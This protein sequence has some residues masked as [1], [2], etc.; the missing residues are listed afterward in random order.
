MASSLPDSPSLDR[1]KA[2]ARRLQRA[3][4]TGDVEA[5]ALY[6]RWHPKPEAAQAQHFPLHSAQLTIARRYGFTGWPALV[7]YLELA[8]DFSRDPGA[9]D[10]TSLSP[11][12]Q[13]CALA[14]LRYD[15]SDE[16]P[17]WAAA[18]AMLADQPD[19]VDAHIWAAAAAGDVEAIRRHL[20]ADPRLTGAQ[21]GPYRW[22]PLLYLVYSRVP[23]AHET[24]APAAASV[25]LDAGADPNTGYLWRGL[26]TP[27]TAL[28]GA[29]GEG[30][31]GPGRQPR[32]PQ[33]M[34]LA[35]VLLQRGADPNDGQALYNRMFTS[36]KD[37]LELLFEFGLG[38]GDGGPW[39]RRLGEALE[40][41]ALALRRQLKWAI[42]HQLTDR[43][44]LLARHHIDLVTPSA[45]GQTPR[46]RAHEMDFFPVIHQLV[47]GG[48]MPSFP[49]GDEVAQAAAILL[50]GP[51][52]DEF[53]RAWLQD[54]PELIA[55]VQQRWP[56]FAV[57]YLP[58][59]Q[60]ALD[61]LAWAGF[62]VDRGSDSN[63]DEPGLR[64]SAE[65]SSRSRGREEPADLPPDRLAAGLESGELSLVFI[66]MVPAREAE[67]ESRIRQLLARDQSAEIL[68]HD[69][70]RHPTLIHRAPDA[71]AIDRIVWAG[72]DVNINLDGRTAL[73]QAAWDGDLTKMQALLHAGADPSIVDDEHHSTPLDW[74]EYAY[75]TE[76]ADLLRTA[77]RSTTPAST[78]ATPTS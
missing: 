42:D 57:G 66:L 38:T 20:L 70:R 67:D 43:V 35:R 75:R 23:A 72:F 25:L 45:D 13:F 5:L 58:R 39:R 55:G 18:R 26:S 19:I 2:D 24:A 78:P 16:P 21:G 30:E 8:L 37:H 6:R 53:A 27:F 59:H 7:G 51:D 60:Q 71:E 50:A 12:D 28:T 29:F 69:R 63:H 31:Q 41:P 11:A 62:D 9:V 32:H 33:S 40:T 52:Q 4:R 54:R 64:P 48:S 65:A 10:E 14:C 56:E 22:T 3:A 73:H 15:A 1:L 68:A 47:L 61:R 44:G 77:T 76:A 36:G 17:R 74:A 34:E 49:G 46:D